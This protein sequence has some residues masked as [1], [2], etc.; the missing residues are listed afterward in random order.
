MSIDLNSIMTLTALRTRQANQ[1]AFARASARLATGKQINSAADNPAGLIASASMNATLA[2]LDAEANT[3]QRA[4]V[5]TSIADGAL[6]QA[7]ELLDQAKGL[8]AAN[9]NSTG[10]S[11]EERAA[12]Q[13]E[14]DS[15]IASVDRLSG[16]TRFA[17]KTLLDGTATVAAPGARLSL[18]SIKSS[19]IGQ[20][21][22]G[23]TTC[24]LADLKS[25]GALDTT[26]SASPS[27]SM[28]VLDT[29]IQNVATLRGQAGA[30][31]KEHIE[32]RLDQIDI[33]RE[34]LIS[35]V[36]MIGD[37][38]M[39]MEVSAAARAQLLSSSSL[40]MLG[41]ALMQSTRPTSLLKATH[42]DVR[43]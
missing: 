1:L 31:L 22:D 18:G 13:L 27:T 16:D 14:I 5:V 20:V 29:A 40:S 17:G 3:N 36:S 41:H 2:A 7:S 21:T 30:F 43:A 28:Q 33:A 35:T 12:N 11:D 26:S 10:L 38:D 23:G 42:L 9:A 32:P 39:A 19:D 24:T 34:H 8:V 4:L 6:G 37:A 25:G 15:I